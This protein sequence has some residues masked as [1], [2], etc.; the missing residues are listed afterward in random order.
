MGTVGQSHRVGRRAQRGI[1]AMGAIVVISIVAGVAMFG[2]SAAP[3][4]FN[5]FT[6]MDIVED[7]S[8]DPQFREQTTRKVRT[9]VAKRFQTNN[10][11]GP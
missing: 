4:Y 11:W 2:M 8:N 3:M 7:I 6:V 9:A 10:L 5:H 1:G